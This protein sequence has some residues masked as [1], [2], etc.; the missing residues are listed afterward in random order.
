[1]TDSSNGQSTAIVRPSDADYN[2]SGA[3]IARRGF[4]TT[5]LEQRRETQ[6]SAAA[7]TAQALVQAQ[8]IMAER[9]PRDRDDVRFRLLKHC[10]RQGF[11]SIAE[12]SKPVGGRAITGPSVRFVE[13]ALQEYGNVRSTNTPIYDDD[14]KRIVKVTVIDLE[15]NLVRE[16]DVT[17]E[18]FV[19]RRKTKSGDEVIGERTNSFGDIVYK[20][21]AIED[22]FTN[23]MNAG[24]S[25]MER[26]LGLKILPPDLVAEAMTRCKA[27]RE[28]EVKSNPDA[29]RNAI[30][31]AFAGVG[32]S[33]AD[34]KEYLGHDLAT[35]SPAELDT[36]RAIWVAIRDG[37][38]TW[39]AALTVAREQRGEIEK[40]VDPAADKLKATLAAAAEKDKARAAKDKAAGNGNSKKTPPKVQWK[41]DG[42]GFIASHG[43]YGLRV[44]PVGPTSVGW[45][46][47]LAGADEATGEVPGE[48]AKGI[49]I[50]KAAAIEA[51]SKLPA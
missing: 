12:Y 51:A 9:R 6:G 20:V 41:M 23:K 48:I 32:V 3:A 2:K 5:E 8:Y 36:M 31:D 4:G 10:D 35:C 47:T 17:A 18:K 19:E 11:A 42:S 1:M 50:A 21:R 49:D 14:E 30:A 45:W 34:L 44:E 40:V 38:G 7:A 16:G 24:I 28:A 26:N 13:A 27:T 37:E 25:K 43:D 29:A 46:V 22:D 33:P 15:R 39:Q